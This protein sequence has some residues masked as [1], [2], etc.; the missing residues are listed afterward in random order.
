MS[1]LLQI[2]ASIDA[3]FLKKLDAWRQKQADH[4]SRPEALRRLAEDSLA[5]NDM[6]EKMQPLC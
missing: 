5:L 6:L 4:P 2:E 1:E 3:V